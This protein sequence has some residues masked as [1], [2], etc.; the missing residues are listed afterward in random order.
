MI[1]Y[2]ADGHA[3]GGTRLGR[4]PTT[5]AGRLWLEALKLA[6]RDIDFR[7]WLAADHVLQAHLARS[8]PAGFGKGLKTSGEVPQV[9]SIAVAKPATRIPVQNQHGVSVVLLSYRRRQNL[10]RI[11]CALRQCNFV[12]EII[13]SNNNPEL[14]IADHLH[15]RDDRLRLIEQPTRCYPSIR[16]E[17]SR[18]ARCRYLISIDDDIFPQPPQLQAL[19]D[20]LRT[21]PQMPHGFG[22]QVFDTSGERQLQLIANRNLRVES[23]VWVFAY[24]LEHVRR[25]FELLA[26]AGLDNEALRFNEDVPLSFAGTDFARAHFVGPIERCPTSSASGIASHREDGFW[27]QRSQLIRSMRDL[28]GRRLSVRVPNEKA[29]RQPA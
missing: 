19:Y 16:L 3:V 1:H 28:T 2:F 4:N 24:T 27:T 17:L 29:S 18:Q 15:V 14:R 13:L 26:A 11:M 23:L 7:P 25:Y 21:D 8:Q 9:A 12:S 10:D 22:G 6:S 20:A 5:L